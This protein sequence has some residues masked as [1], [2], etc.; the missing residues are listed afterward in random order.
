MGASGSGQAIGGL[1]WRGLL[2]AEVDDLREAMTFGLHGHLPVTQRVSFFRDLIEIGLNA[3]RNGSGL[4]PSLTSMLAFSRAFRASKSSNCLCCAVSYA[5]RAFWRR[6]ASGST[7]SAEILAASRAMSAEAGLTPFGSWKR[8]CG[9]V[10]VLL[11]APEVW[12][13]CF[14][15][16]LCFRDGGRAWILEFCARLR[17]HGIGE[18]SKSSRLQLD[19]TRCCLTAHA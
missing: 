2:A 11:T 4:F 15:G 9:L 3:R 14:R 7:S 6:V 12:K 17:N 1:A 16:I 10:S 13:E 5:L 19:R 8:F 18:W